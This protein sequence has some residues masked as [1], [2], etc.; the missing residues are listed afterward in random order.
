MNSAYLFQAFLIFVWWLAITVSPEAYSYFEFSTLGQTQFNYFLVPDLLILCLLSLVYIR[1]KFEFIKFIILGGFAYAT[2]FCFSA[3]LHS[4][5][6]YISSLAMLFGLIFNAFLCF[7]DKLFRQ[8]K[9]TSFVANFA[10]TI[11]QTIVVWS[12]I[13]FIFPNLIDNAIYGKHEPSP[14]TALVIVGSILFLSFA[15]LGLTSGFFM[16]RH[17]S[18]TPLPIDST[19]K[20]V[21]VGPYSYIRNPMAIAGIGQAIAISVI[22]QSLPIFIYSLLGFV[23]WNYFVRPIEEKDLLL[24][25]GNDFSLYTKNV[26]CWVPRKKAYSCP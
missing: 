8:S 7:E 25:F 2:L 14:S 21:I 13:L 17:G 11:M 23:V 24:K 18:G 19:K 4:S 12:L 10:K 3:T 5:S 1:Y 6:G 9:T 16:A 20:L 15:S 22:Y 26:K